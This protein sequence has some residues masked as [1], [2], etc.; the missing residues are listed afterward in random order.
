M[1]LL[2]V[3]GPHHMLGWLSKLFFLRLRGRQCVAI[4]PSLNPPGCQ[5]ISGWLATSR[6]RRTLEVALA[7]D[8]PMSPNAF[9]RLSFNEQ[10]HRPFARRQNSLTVLALLNDYPKGI[11]HRVRGL[12]PASVNLPCRDA[13]LLPGPA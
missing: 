3:H 5:R 8:S 11:D 1:E 6:A 9:T 7:H 12:Q 4:E 2:D 10:L 13:L